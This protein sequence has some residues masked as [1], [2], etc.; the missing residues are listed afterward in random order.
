MGVEAVTLSAVQIPNHRHPLLARG[1]AGTAAAPAGN[2]A[3]TAVGNLY[4]STPTGPTAA[5]SPNAVATVGGSQPHENLQPYLC[6][7]YIISLFGI[8][9]TQN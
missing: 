1:A 7:S 4:V 8:F 9:P 3:A 5:L 2:L 6:V